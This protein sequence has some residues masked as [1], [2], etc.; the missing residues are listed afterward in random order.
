MNPIEF[1][2]WLQGHF[3]MSTAETLTPAQAEMVKQHLALVFKKETLP[4]GGYDLF[5]NDNIGLWKKGVPV[6][7]AP[8][9]IC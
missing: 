8:D 6:G 1:C 5:S 7:K 4:A 9:I 2:Y 3:E